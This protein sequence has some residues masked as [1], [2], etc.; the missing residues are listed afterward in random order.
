MGGA[1]YS[2]SNKR[3]YNIPGMHEPVKVPQR[4]EAPWHEGG[5]HNDPF[6]D[7]WKRLRQA[8][9]VMTVIDYLE[10]WKKE[11]ECGPESVY[12]YKRELMEKTC[13]EDSDTMRKMLDDVKTKVVSKG[14]DAIDESIQR[15]YKEL[16]WNK[17]VHGR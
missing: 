13:F 5:D 4:A 6:E 16:G 10:M 12:H 1:A 15:L 3:I 8:I 14:T 9:V 11:L 7:P 17:N 2:A